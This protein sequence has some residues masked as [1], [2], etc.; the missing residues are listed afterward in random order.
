MKTSTFNLHLVKFETDEAP[1]WEV[2]RQITSETPYLL[3]LK[4]GGST[5]FQIRDQHEATAV[6]DL[7]T[8][9]INHII[10]LEFCL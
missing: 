6:R 5:V 7:L 9:A 1:D 3:T 10:D 4:C 8:E 2:S